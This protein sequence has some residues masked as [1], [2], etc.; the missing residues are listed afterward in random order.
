MQSGMS[1]LTLTSSTLYDEQIAKVNEAMGALNLDNLFFDDSKTS[2]IDTII[3]SIRTMK[4]KFDI[5]G[6]VLDY[7]QILNVNM[8][9]SN[10]EQQ[11]A[12]VARRLK[13]LAMEM[14]IWIVALSQL[15][16]N[17]DYPYP[18][19]HRLRDSGQIAEAADMVICTFIA[20]K[21]SNPRHRCYP[22]PFE[23]V[24]PI[25][26]AMIDIVKGRK[27]G[28]AKFIVGFRSES[29]EF[30]ELQTTPIKL[31]DG[32]DAPPNTGDCPF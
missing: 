7:M 18:T 15:N 25:G 5:D 26:T 13:N 1:S 3:A 21:A 19:I 24:S 29:T 8:K 6:V 31:N 17:V 9:S 11:M 12:S 14:D 2:N 30:Y 20:E 23:Q 22:E 32:N 16:R 10:V 27:V 28:T 4:L